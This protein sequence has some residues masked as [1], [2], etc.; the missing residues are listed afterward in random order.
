MIPQPPPARTRN[1]EEFTN[2]W[3]HN[4]ERGG[5]KLMLADE[6]R[7]KFYAPFVKPALSEKDKERE[8]KRVEFLC[9][10]DVGKTIA[11][12]PPSKIRSSKNAGR[13]QL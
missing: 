4:T 7:V 3:N 8:M 1:I 5:I 2:L 11:K 12:R 6:H 13:R 10:R 9:Q